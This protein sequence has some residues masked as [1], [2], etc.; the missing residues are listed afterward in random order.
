MPTSVELTAGI[1]AFFQVLRISIDIIIRATQR[2]AAYDKRK[3]MQDKGPAAAAS[4]VEKEL[5]VDASAVEA[6][7]KAIWIKF[8]IFLHFCSCAYFLFGCVFAA[9]SSNDFFDEEELAFEALPMGCAAVVNGLFLL[10]DLTDGVHAYERFGHFAR[11]C[12]LFSNILVLFSCAF[13]MLDEKSSMLGDIISLVILACG[14]AFA[15]LECKMIPYP[16]ISQE[17]QNQRRALLSKKALLMILKPYFWP[18]ATA[19]SATL[20][21]I[22]AMLT[23]VFVVGSK[24]CSLLGELI[25]LMYS[26]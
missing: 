4:S 6:G 24:C 21:R 12:Y 9:M 23:W 22:R 10:S 19:T 2:D 14:T 15:A 8:G 26:E 7:K 20:N 3:E 17:S 13:A 11:T 16:K 1:G 25:F 5:L 18:K